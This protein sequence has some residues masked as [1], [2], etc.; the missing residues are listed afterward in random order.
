MKSKKIEFVILFVA[1]IF[2]LSCS[3]GVFAQ[4]ERFS[5]ATGGTSG[6]YYPIGGAIADIVSKF[7]PGVELTAES[8]GASV[9]NLK[10]ARQGEVDFLMGAA[11]TTF[12]AFSGED[13]FDEEV[14]NIRGITALYPE[15]FQFIVREDS[16]IKG[17]NDLK[18]KKVVVGAPGSGTERTTGL[19]LGMYGMTYDDIVPEFLS[20]AEGV[21]ALKDRTVDCA[22][23]GAGV[24]TAAVI[25]AAASMDIALVPI[26]NDVFE[27][28]A[29]E[30]PYLAANVIPAGLYSGVDEDIYTVASPAL[31]SVRE[32]ISE[33]VV[34]NIVKAIFEHTDVLA[35]THA[36]GKNIKLENALKG[37]SIPL[38]PGAEKYYKEM[39]IE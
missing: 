5:L 16:G 14:K 38:H 11:N 9:A 22:V 28:H 23:V 17:F 6:T 12:A 34:Y 1:F 24:P 7:V 37:M 2:A 8:T 13:P 21:E 25:D 31:L 27:Q 36:Q 33:E 32:D 30:H 26:D 4:V 35:E 29:K 39:G 20:F 10:M 19:L 15:T 18:G 3:N